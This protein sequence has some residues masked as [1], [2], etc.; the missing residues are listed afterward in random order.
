MRDH[1]NAVAIVNNTLTLETTNS[2]PVAYSD[3]K[4]VN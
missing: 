2:G 4:A 1:V 3:V